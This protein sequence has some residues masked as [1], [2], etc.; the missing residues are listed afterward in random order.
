[1][2]MSNPIVLILSLTLV[3]L[4]AGGCGFEQIASEPTLVPPTQT[5][6]PIPKTET[7][8]P[9]I[10]HT[11]TPTS[12][13]TSTPMF[14]VTSTLRPT[15]TPTPQP[16]WITGFVDPILAAI[17]MQEPDFQ[18]DFSAPYGGWIKGD[19]CADWRFK[20][21]DGE[22]VVSDCQV[23]RDMWYPDFVIEM[24]ARFLP[25]SS[26]DSDNEWRYRFRR[27]YFFDFEYNGQVE[28]GFE[29][30]G[31]PGEYT[32][33]E[34]AIRSGANTNHVLIIV[35]DQEVALIVNDRPVYHG[36][37]KPVWKN[38]RME[39]S[40]GDTV[41]VDNFKIWDISDIVLSAKPGP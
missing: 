6:P 19:W 40:F 34:G 20:I 21:A 22:M 30:P 23:E 26:T 2:K 36:V 28:V 27:D 39:W 14:P 8:T 1:M 33:I 7:T 9:A 41:A 5:S 15:R 18:D 37:M 25:G 4:S 3:L 11:Q 35:K 24:D 12:T 32:R 29:E 38:G 16:D 17:A 13:P 10:W 31:S